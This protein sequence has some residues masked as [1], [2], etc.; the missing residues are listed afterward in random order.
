MWSFELKHRSR[1]QH[2]FIQ[3]ETRGKEDLPPRVPLLYIHCLNGG[4]YFIQLCATAASLHFTLICQGLQCR[5]FNMD[6]T[7][8]WYF[9]DSDDAL[10]L[11]VWNRY[12]WCTCPE[13]LHITTARHG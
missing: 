12:Y 10:L 4:R 7:N 6:P 11:P 9:S 5:R 3:I 13:V 8:R 2:S 1:R